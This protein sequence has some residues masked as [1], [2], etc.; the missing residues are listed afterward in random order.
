MHC[1][2]WSSDYTRGGKMTFYFSIGRFH[3]GRMESFPATK[4]DLL[5]LERKL[6]ANTAEIIADLKAIETQQKKSVEEIKA[7]QASVDELKKKINELEE[8]IASAPV[9]QELADAVA[10]VKSQAQITDDLIPDAPT[11]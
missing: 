4:H 6:M 8:I 10:A 3:I 1:D 2:E 5:K 9:S 11:V 7:V